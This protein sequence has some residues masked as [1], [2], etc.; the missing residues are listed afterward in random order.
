MVVLKRK[1][2]EKLGFQMA[3][4]AVGHK[5]SKKPGVFVKEVWVFIIAHAPSST[6]TWYQVYPGG[7]AARN[8]RLVKG[9][10]ILEV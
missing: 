5:A 9:D 1:E 8:G 4:G 3:G 10:R 6:Y 2:G 7:L